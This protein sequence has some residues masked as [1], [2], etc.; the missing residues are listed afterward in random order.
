MDPETR[1]P[2]ARADALWSAAFAAARDPAFALHA[3]EALPFGA[4][5]TVDF[6]C[7]H[8][9][10]VRDA[11]RRVAEFFQLVDVRARIEVDD[12]ARTLTML[13]VG[14]DPVPPPAQEYT[15]AA[16]V[17]RMAVCV[18]PGWSPREVEFAFAPIPNPREHER[19]LR[20]PVSFGAGAPRLRFSVEAWETPVSGA[21]P[22][23]LAVLEDHARRLYAELPPGDDLPS[24]ARST[25][26]TELRAGHEGGPSASHV[27]RQL[28]TSE[29]TL[30]RRL[31][32][33]DLSFAQLLDE[34]REALARAHLRDPA[35]SLVEVAWL[36]G[37]SD[38][39][40]FTRAFRRW[41]GRPPGAW[42]KHIDSQ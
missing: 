14:G 40:A 2:A 42:R 8:S 18:G 12:E 37:F 11:Y 33:H 1:L 5:R 7:A 41:T 4:Y 10:C 15:F 21:N 20:A 17:S 39:S 19:V 34:A 28:G 16:L 32:E 23:L 38:Q 9:P 6:L 35:L 36:L 25:I 27:A 30:Q 24:R 26:A 22:A 31:R 29:R 13:T 3:A